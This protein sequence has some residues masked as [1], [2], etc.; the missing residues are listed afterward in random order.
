[1]VQKSVSVIVQKDRILVRL[2][3]PD[4]S[5]RADGAF[6]HF[7]SAVA[8]K[9]MGSDQRPGGAVHFFD[10]QRAAVLPQKTPVHDIRNRGRAD[11]VA[12][13]FGGSQIA[14]V[15]TFGGAHHLGNGDILGKIMIQG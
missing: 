10:V 14:G 7:K 3:D 6:F 12:V 13:P 1:M 9:V 11:S 8:G 15:K 5:D 4:V 2:C